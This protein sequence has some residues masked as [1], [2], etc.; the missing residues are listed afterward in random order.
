MN[1]ELEDF[2]PEDYGYQIS[3]IIQGNKIL[4]EVYVDDNGKK[5]YTFPS[6]TGVSKKHSTLY[7][8]PDLSGC[9]EGKLGIGFITSCTDSC[10]PV[11][12]WYV[13][14]T[15]CKS[16]LF[17]YWLD[18]DVT[19]ACTYECKVICSGKDD[20]EDQISSV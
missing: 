18:I 6:V 1:I 19:T 15:L 7:T 9:Y 13:N 5:I 17:G 12:E 8:F 20:H 10:N 2:V 3:Q 16:A 11:Y 4:L 14:G